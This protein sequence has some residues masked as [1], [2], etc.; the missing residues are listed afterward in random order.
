MQDIDKID[1]LPER[2]R[3]QR[4]RRRRIVG[5]AYFLVACLIG[6]VL[7]GYGQHCRVA[8]ASA[9]LTTL[10]TQVEDIRQRLS[11]RG[12]LANREAELQI[13]AR[14]EADLGSRVE[15]L[16]VLSELERVMPT[17]IVLRD[18]KLETK[19]FSVAIEPLANH[20]PHRKGGRLPRPKERKVKRI[21]LLLTGLS[22]T[23]VDV[24][25]CVGQ[26][27]A[28]PLFEEVNMAYARQGKCRGRNA[29]EFQVSCFVAR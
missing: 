22:P 26:L 19:E 16:D 3:V 15:V 5:Q 24:A 8:E 7:L 1:F 4:S 23:D 9:E 13:F 27:S 10:D 6:M 21:R 11:L 29:R 2:V 18:L 20:E 12:E 25:N 28:S 14:I 17:S